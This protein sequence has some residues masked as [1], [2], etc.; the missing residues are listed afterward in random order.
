MKVAATTVQRPT[1]VAFRCIGHRAISESSFGLD[2]LDGA[3]KT[4]TGDRQL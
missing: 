2:G 4:A 3:A 1:D